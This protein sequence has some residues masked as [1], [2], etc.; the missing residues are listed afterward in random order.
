MLYGF[1]YNG[2]RRC[3]SQAAQ[4]DPECA[5]A[6]WGLAIA[7]GPTINDTG[8]GAA[9]S[10]LALAEIQRALKAKHVSPLEL[11]LIRAQQTRFSPDGPA[12]RNL[13]NAAYAQAMGK[14][15][16]NHQDDPDVGALYAEALLDQRPWNQWSKDGKPMPGTVDAISTLR[17]VLT[18]NPRHPQALHMTIHAVESSPHPEDALKAADT[19]FDL[20]PDLGHMQH[21][22]CHIY[23][24]TG[25][26]AKSVHASQVAIAQTNAYLKS[27]G[28]EFVGPSLDH[29]DHAL[30]YAA[31]MLGQS[32]VAL[33][34]LNLDNVTP[35]WIEK[36]GADYDTDLALP[37]KVLQRFG[38]WDEILAL[39]PFGSKTPFATAMRMGA[40]AVAFAAM[41]RLKEAKEAQREFEKDCQAVP[42][43]VTWNDF[44]KAADILNIERHL[45][46]GE[47]LI[48]EAGQ[49]NRAISELKLAVKAEDSL[50][51]SEPPSWIQP[52]RHALGAAFIQLQRYREAE[53]VYREDIR[54]I[55]PCGWS[56]YGLG[57]SLQGQGRQSEA[58]RTMQEFT[59]AWKS[60]DVQINSSCLCLP[61]R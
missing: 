35:E 51:Y 58:K 6:H 53:A 26:W 3:F 4:A 7:E 52:T 22:P 12:E 20:Q 25:Q 56:L 59:E 44:D 33:K 36:N 48:R 49:E 46:N 1:Q 2:A 17:T 45:M 13:L 47:I 30:A 60:A 24:R 23:N 29:Y 8:V 28:V 57:K 55:R 11:E 42:A 50:H 16:R 40:R 14:V 18:L 10:K 27:R 31:S 38:K 34:A 32:Q 9:A 5:M 15:W 61:A 43:S 41:G 19:L 21:M 39:K 37:V 54:K